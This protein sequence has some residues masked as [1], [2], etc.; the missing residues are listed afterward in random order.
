ME[1]HFAMPNP[2]P[3]PGRFGTGVLLTSGKG[4]GRRKDDR[5]TPLFL[6]QI[7]SRIKMQEDA[8]KERTIFY[9]K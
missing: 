6:G 4:F 2:L 1:S 9:D 5:K 8:P 7:G 3:R